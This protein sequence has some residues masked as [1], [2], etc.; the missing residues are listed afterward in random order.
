MHSA[1]TRPDIE[2]ADHV[3]LTP[4][5]RSSTDIDAIVDQLRAVP[6][7]PARVRTGVRYGS[8]SI[9][10]PYRNRG[11]EIVTRAN[12]AGGNDHFAWWP[13]ADE[14]TPIT[15]DDLDAF[16]SIGRR[17]IEAMAA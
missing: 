5:R 4:G 17:R 9:T 3:D 14:P 10:D 15:P 8:V 16:A 13:T 6:G 11:C 1:S 7:R 12:P 2:W